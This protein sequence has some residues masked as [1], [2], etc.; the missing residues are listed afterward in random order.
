MGKAMKAALALLS[1]GGKAVDG[2]KVNE[3]LRKRLG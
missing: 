1:A 2:R 3:A